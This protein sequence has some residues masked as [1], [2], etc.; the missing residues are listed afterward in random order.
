MARKRNHSHDTAMN[1]MLSNIALGFIMLFIIAVI[2]MNPIT[3]RNDVPSK[4]EVM[5]IMSWDTESN[6]DVD[7]WIQHE[8]DP[9]VGFSNKNSGFVNLDRDDLGQSNDTAI[10]DG[11][12]VINKINRETINIRGILPGNYYVMAQMYSRR[13]RHGGPTIVTVTVID[14]NPYREAYTMT[15]E[16][17][18]TG[19]FARFPGFTLDADGNITDI[20]SHN[21]SV[22]GRRNESGSS[23]VFTY[24]PGGGPVTGGR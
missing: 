22:I 4:N 16:M 12:P 14:V 3:K 20:F 23:E 8:N 7:L 6:D 5:I 18:N 19:D 17:N 2:L 13:D 10:I 1:D 15:V 9:P 21:R 24:G 11:K